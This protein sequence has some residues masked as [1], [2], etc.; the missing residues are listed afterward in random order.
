MKKVKRL[1]RSTVSFVVIFAMMSSMVFAG[2]NLNNFSIDSFT[3][4]SPNEILQGDFAEIVVSFSGGGNIRP[5]EDNSLRVP[6]NFVINGDGEIDSTET[7]TQ[8]FPDSPG[9]KTLNYTIRINTTPDTP[10]GSYTINLIDASYGFLDGDDVEVRINNANVNFTVIEKAP[11]ITTLDVTAN[12]ENKTYDGNTDAS[13]T[14]QYDVGEDDVTVNYTNAYFETSN[15]GSDVLVTVKGL[16]LSGNDMNKY[17]L[18]STTITTTADINKAD[19]VITVEGKTVTYNGEAYGATGT[20]FGFNGEDLSESLDLGNSFTDVPGGTAAWNFSGNQNYND[21]SGTVE[22][23]IGKATADIS[24]EGPTVRYDGNPHGLSGMATGADGVNLSSLLDLGETYTEATV[25]DIEWTF[26]GDNNHSA[27]SGKATLT[28]SEA[29]LLINAVGDDS[30]IYDGEAFDNFDVT[31]DGFI[32]G[33]DASDLTGEL[34]WEIL[35]ADGETVDEAINAGTYTITP[36][37]LSS[38]NYDIEFVSAEITLQ[39]ADAEISVIGKTVTYNGNAQSAS[40]TATGI[41]DEDLSEWLD[42][43]ETFTNASS[44]EAAWNFSGHSNYNDASGSVEI[45]IEKAE[46][47]I[48]V[49]NIDVEYDGTT[50]GLDGTAIGVNDEDLTDLMDFG[51]RFTDFPGGTATWTF[52]GNTNYLPVSGNAKITITKADLIVTAGDDSKVYDGDAFDAFDITFDGF[53]GDDDASMLDGEIQWEILDADGETVEESVNAGTYT[54]IPSGLSSNNYNITYE[55]GDIT[56]TKAYA[57]I[58]VEGKNVTYDGNA[59]SAT[60]TARGVKGEDLSGLLSLG[61]SFINV[62]GGTADWNFTGNENYNDAS[63]SVAIVINKADAV[64][65]VPDVDVDYTGNPHSATG[66]AFGVNDEGLIDFMD[67]GESFT[68]APGGNTEWT[69][70]GS[71]NYNDASG[72]VTIQIHRVHADITVS[73]IS[74]DYDGTPHGLEGTATGVQGEDLSNLLNLGDKFTNV[75]GGTATWTFGGDTNYLPASDKAKVIITEADLVVAAVTDSKVYDG[76]AFENF[77]VT[78]NGF[79]GDDDA[80]ILEGELEWEIRD[81]DGHVVESAINVGI[82]TIIPSGLENINYDIEFLNAEITIHPRLITLKATDAQKIYGEVDPE[83]SYEIT[84]GNLA[85]GDVFTGNITREL[86][87]SVG[88]YEIRR[89]SLA[90]NDVYEND[91]YDLTFIPG[92]L[93]ITPRSITITADD[94]STVYGETDPGLT[95]G[96]TEGSLAHGDAFTGNLAREDGNNVGTYGITRGTLSI[97]DVFDNPNYDLNFIDGEFSITVKPI[98]VTADDKFKVYGEDDPALTYQITEGSLAYE[99]AFSGELTRIEGENVREYAIE[100]GTLQLSENYNLTVLDG[101][102]TITPR[103]IIVTADD[104]S[105]IYGADDPELTFTYDEEQLMEGDEYTG[106]LL[107]EPGEAVGE[108]TLYQGDLSLGENY[109]MDFV[110]GT[111]SISYGIQGL[112]PTGSD[113]EIICFKTGRAIPLK[114]A[115]VD[116]NGDVADSSDF[117]LQVQYR[118]IDSEDDA[119]DINTPGNSSLSYN[120]NTGTWQVNWHTK[121]M[122]SGVYELIIFD[123]ATGQMDVFYIELK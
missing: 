27:S 53:K 52:P 40:G 120:I 33:E 91:N 35:D 46:A 2:V 36:K 41:N 49:S 86:G 50:Q 44:E 79:E 48:T 11:D 85:E 88:T 28:I 121:G 23:E 62:P 73:D 15:A 112:F 18:A 75:P 5:N 105:K 95:Y 3:G 1:I 118:Q 61:D 80:S 106:S 20:A 7:K 98:T 115:Y 107:R 97:N 42:L 96:I 71:Q 109:D 103:L 9:T 119:Y 21:A 77:N 122:D 84:I 55:S 17:E 34:E 47:T 56:I 39:K 100:Q 111:F 99:D 72:N 90:I 67:F 30:K 60:G 104:I 22:I 26:A 63:G 43:G 114:W 6:V 51:E 93:K 13:V 59:H 31:Y 110:E 94:T 70:E 14:L 83:L 37:G 117:L 81:A 16:D 19:A 69:F 108:Y 92:E 82:Y 4:G 65:N 89:G 113:D 12:A 68:N 64:I 76:T 78:I 38:N 10:S 54:I 123:E 101:K 25:T 102:F 74:F 8:I 58:S 45:I 116:A 66:T 87:Q 24:I 29:D 32:D 57:A